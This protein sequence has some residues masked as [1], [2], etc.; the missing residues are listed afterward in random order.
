VLAAL[1]SCLGRSL[2]I[3]RE[4]PATAAFATVL[5]VGAAGL[6]LLTAVALLAALLPCFGGSLR[7]VSEVSGPA[8]MFGGHSRLLSHAITNSTATQREK[9]ADLEASF[10]LH[11]VAARIGRRT[12]S[13]RGGTRHILLMRGCGTGNLSRS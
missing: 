1:P 5:L 10:P 9:N 4:V 2:G 11:Y 7:I 8:S 3:F 6:M 12:S 13:R